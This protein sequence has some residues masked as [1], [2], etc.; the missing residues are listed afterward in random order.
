MGVLTSCV[1]T[2]KE[3]PT[4]KQLVDIWKLESETGVKY[5]VYKDRFVTEKE[6]DSL[7]SLEVNESIKEI[8]K[9]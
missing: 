8:F 3:F 2:Q 6:L 9:K 7:V 4:D 5:F 1:T